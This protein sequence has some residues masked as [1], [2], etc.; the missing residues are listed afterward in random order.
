M[1]FDPASPARR[2]E[3]MEPALIETL[4]MAPGAEHGGAVIGLNMVAMR[5]ETGRRG[6]SELC[7]TSVVF[8]SARAPSRRHGVASSAARPRPGGDDAPNPVG[9]ARC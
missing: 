5:G 2:R 9:C 8:L 3:D 7:R 1:E 6:P 4:M